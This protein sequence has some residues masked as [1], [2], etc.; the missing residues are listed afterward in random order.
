LEFVTRALQG[1]IIA[2]DTALEIAKGLQRESLLGGGLLDRQAAIALHCL[3]DRYV[4][5]DI[6]RRDLDII[7]VVAS[8]CDQLM[9]RNNPS[10][11]YRGSC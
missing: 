1:S 11:S 9:E 2:L 6:S 10:P 3:V 8:L 5:F 7:T 4:F